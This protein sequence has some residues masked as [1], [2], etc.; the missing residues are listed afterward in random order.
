MFIEDG[1]RKLACTERDRESWEK[2]SFQYPQQ[3]LHSDS[4]QHTPGED[5]C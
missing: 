1:K 3:W 5:H 4:V 2:P